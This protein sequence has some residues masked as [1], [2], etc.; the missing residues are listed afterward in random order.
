MF[1]EVDIPTELNLP[2]FTLKLAKTMFPKNYCKISFPL[3][4]W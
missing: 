2:N 3:K 1:V 4:H